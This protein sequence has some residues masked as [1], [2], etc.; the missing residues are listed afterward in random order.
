M[1][2]PISPPMCAPME[3]LASVKLRIRLITISPPMPDCWM[4]SPRARSSTTA[5]P[6]SPKIAPEAPRLAASV[7]NTTPKE[8]T[9]SEVK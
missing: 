8:P 5:A 6:I 7:A 9:S 4:L 2:P 3:M 1:K